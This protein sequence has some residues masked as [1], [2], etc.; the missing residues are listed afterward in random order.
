M[1]SSTLLLWRVPE[2]STALQDTEF[3]L[4]SVQQAVDR[5]FQDHDLHRDG[6]GGVNPGTY[7]NQASVQT[8]NLSLNF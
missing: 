8:L 3:L 5:L 6:G 2:G 1:L 4:V 7:T